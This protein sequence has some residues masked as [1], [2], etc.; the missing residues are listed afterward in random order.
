[1]PLVVFVGRG[2]RLWQLFAMCAHLVLTNKKGYKLWTHLSNVLQSCAPA[3]KNGVV[4]Y[5]EAARAVNPPWPPLDASKVLDYVFL[6]EF[7]ILCDSQYNVQEQQW[8]QPT[9]RAATAAYFKLQCSY[10]KIEHLD[11]EIRRLWAYMH[12]EE[13]LLERT[14]CDLHPKQSL[15]AHQVLLKLKWLQS[16]NMVHRS[17]LT[18]IESLSGYKGQK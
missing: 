4:G 16:A 8:A 6:S 11:V 5:N 12:D 13:R 3:I 14:I 7:D 17:Q 1:M 18:K 2:T 10:K 15:L 9:E